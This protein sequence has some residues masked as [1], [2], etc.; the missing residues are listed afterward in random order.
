MK[1]IA[2]WSDDSNWGVVPYMHE[3]LKELCDESQTEVLMNGAAWIYRHNIKEP[4][5]DYKRRCLLALWSP[6]EFTAKKDY[7]HF[8]HYDFFTDVYCVCPLT[9]KFMNEHYGYEKFKYIPYPYTNRSVTEFGDYDADCSWMG[10]IHGDDHIKAVEVME[11]FKYKFMTSQR[12]TW[13][14]HPYE[15]NK[16]TH[17]MLSNDEKLKQLSK[18]RSSLSFNMIYMSPAS[19]ENNGESFS[20]FKEGIMPQFKVRSHEITSS[21]S[22]MIVKKDPWNLVE[23]FYE[24]GK[25]FVYFENFKQLE[26]IIED[27]SK[28]FHNYEHIIEAAY[29]KSKNYT[30]ENIYRYIQTNDKSLI[31]W[32]NKHV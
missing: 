12:N 2:D 1:I 16:C 7:Y 15:F 23:D 13:M 31:T 19:I 30:V 6:C 4:F 26:E 32:S 8:D 28:N 22:L 27:V 10:S 18:C 21:K 14:R 17:V 3:S 29:V 9:C 25:E 5:K 24:P 20:K 11:K